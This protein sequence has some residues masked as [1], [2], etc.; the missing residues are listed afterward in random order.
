MADTI[1]AAE[2]ARMLRAAAA[3]IRDTHEELGRLDAA[4]GDG[5]HGMAMLKAAE[6]VE[7][8]VEA[9]AGEPISAML[10][11]VGWEVMCIDGGS[12]GPL[13]GSLFMGM[14]ECAG[15]TEALDCAATAAVF[16]AGLAGVQEQTKA[17]PGDKTMID[18][19]VP[20]VEAIRAAADAGDAIIDAMS[21]AA[22][23]AAI[24]AET[25]KQMQAKFGRAK[26][27]GERTVGHAD[28]GAT[29]MAYLFAG[30]AA[31]ASA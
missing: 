17:Q 21:A 22:M 11:A 20:A 29:S 2:I 23:A 19:L 24:G 7:K 25:T 14:S 31:G 30:F 4:T 3:K 26:N 5:D 1:G 16:E 8:A 18:A 28:P 13:L 6:A 27:L 15:E 9:S 12:T 10:H